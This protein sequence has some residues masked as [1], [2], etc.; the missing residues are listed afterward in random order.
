MVRELVREQIGVMVND[1]IDTTRAKLV[2]LKIASV[3]DVRSAGAQIGGFSDDLAARERQLKAF[4]YANLYHH[5]EQQEAANTAHSH[6]CRTV[7]GLFSRQLAASCRLA[8][9]CAG[10]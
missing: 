2:N 1:V 6:H 4:M 10:G 9:Q 5:P 3:E 8:N 7:S